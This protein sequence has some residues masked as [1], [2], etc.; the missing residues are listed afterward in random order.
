MTPRNWV[1]LRWLG[2]AVLLAA[3]AAGLVLR[4]RLGI[5]WS[6][7][8]VRAVVDDLGI[9]APIGFTGIVAVRSLL[10]LPSQLVLTVGGLAFGTAGGTVWGGLGL[11]LNGVAI[12]AVVRWLGLESVRTRVPKALHRALDAAGGRAGAAGLA[13]AT[14]YPVGPIAIYQAAAGLTRMSVALYLMAA[15]LGCFGRAGLYAT[16]GGGLVEGRTIQVAAA[17][18]VI[19]ISLIPLAHPRV[20][21]RLAALLERPGAEAAHREGHAGSGPAGPEG[22]VSAGERRHP[23]QQGDRNAP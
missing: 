14:S 19:A 10:L 3:I 1:R 4:A 5:E 11:L 2:A 6:L 21:A 16:F 8:S 22:D 15:T 9:W 13:V 23:I 17:L 20:R 12:F 18:G 7:E